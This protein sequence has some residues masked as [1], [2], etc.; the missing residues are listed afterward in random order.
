MKVPF[1]DLGAA[2]REI[3]A[4]VRRRLQRLFRDND[5]I[6]GRDVR[7][8][9]SAFSRFTGARFTVG[10]NSG[11]DAL[12]LAL[13]AFGIGPGDEVIVPVYTYIASAY[14]VTYTGAT[15]VFVDI[16]PETY[17]IDADKLRGAVTRRTRAV[18]PV[19]LYGQCAD[20]PA[21]RRLAKERRLVVLEDAAQAHGACLKGR[22]AGTWGDAAAFSFY[23]TK[24]L[25]GV[26]DGG[27][28]T[29]SDR[30]LAAR[31]LKMRD[32][33]R[34]ARYEHD[35]IGYNSRLDTL[36][37]VFLTEKLGRLDRWNAARR[38]VAALY[39]RLLEGTADVV[40]PREMP[41][42]THVYHIFAVRVP[43]RDLVLEGLKRAGI[44]AAVHYPV[45]LHLQKVYRSLG[46]KRGAFPE[47][48]K[49]ASQILCL[50]IHPHMTPAQVH[51]VVRALKKLLASNTGRDA[52]VG[53]F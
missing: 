49:A 53:P 26:G 2:H 44:G 3:K 4:G 24:N 19:H 8:F 50:P 37:A 46:H 40:L 25:G 6:L 23:P 51:C 33:G 42:A 39:R 14:A 38:R 52:S 1:L 17:N 31:V 21:I 36:Q 28:V 16:D 34:I 18:M 9:E 41:G 5:Y 47:A 45:P 20:M 35:E 29:T 27:A 10:V 30:S 12:F 11:T 22:R 13:R 32:Y 43:R 7:D 48:E 15:P